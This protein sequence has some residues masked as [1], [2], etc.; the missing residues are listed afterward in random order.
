MSN[1]RFMKLSFRAKSA[2]RRLLI[3]LYWLGAVLRTGAL[4]RSHV[5]NQDDFL[6]YKV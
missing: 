1:K 5:K 4:P 2:S 6:Q 3:A